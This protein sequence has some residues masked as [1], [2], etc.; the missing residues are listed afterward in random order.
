MRLTINRAALLSGGLTAALLFQPMRVSASDSFLNQ[1]VP[2]VKTLQFGQ[3]SGNWGLPL[4]TPLLRV[5]ASCLLI[6]AC[7]LL[8]LASSRE[9]QR[10][11][12][13]QQRIAASL[14]VAVRSG[15]LDE[16]QR[17]D[18]PVW[19]MWGEDEETDSAPKALVLSRY[20]VLGY[21]G[22]LRERDLGCEDLPTRTI[23]RPDPLEVVTDQELLLGIP[24]TVIKPERQPFPWAVDDT[25][26]P[27]KERTPETG[28]DTEPY[29]I[30][31]D[32]L[33]ASGGLEL[34]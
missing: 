33:V 8:T 20:R 21:S 16:V 19:S 14:S 18:T 24:R 6:A 10:K 31:N 12:R 32:L 7:S 15:L 30:S 26:L 27:S 23:V 25:S 1:S 17:S 29:Q 22:E 4:W 5:G 2:S 11:K 28:M 34:Q 9:N 13:D 3:Q